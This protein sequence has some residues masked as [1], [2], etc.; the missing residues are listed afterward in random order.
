MKQIKYHLAMAGYTYNKFSID[1][2]LEDLE[3][4]DVHYL[5]VKNFHLPFDSSPAQIAEFKKKCS[6]HGVTPYG[7]GPITMLTPDDA[8]T[9]EL[10]AGTWRDD[11]GQEFVG[12]KTVQ[13]EGVP[14][15]RLPR[16]ELISPLLNSSH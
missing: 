14:L 16:Y 7:A 4:F 11:L 2:T 1:K 8:K 15:A 10:P 9:V 5:C 13:L 3:R 12:P 6:D